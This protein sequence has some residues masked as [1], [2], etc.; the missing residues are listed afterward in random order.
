MNLATAF[1]FDSISLPVWAETAIRHTRR[2]AAQSQIIFKAFS[3]TLAPVIATTA[4]D[5]SHY[6]MQCGQGAG[7]LIMHRAGITHNPVQAAVRAAY[8]EL[9]SDASLTTYRRIGDITRETA[10]DALVVGL[11]G[12]A[13][14]SV[15]VDVV[16]KGY[17]TA[18][19]LYRAVYARLKPQRTGPQNY[20]RA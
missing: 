6:Y 14:I 3:K 16:Q 19:K 9:S 8:A 20:C 10:M 15:G 18:A 12:V 5:L 1:Q 7:E 2:A 11:C 13:A 4:K 17:R